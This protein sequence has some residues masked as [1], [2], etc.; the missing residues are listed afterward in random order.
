MADEGKRI[1]TRTDVGPVDINQPFFNLEQAWVIKG[2]VCAWNTFR[3]VRFIQPRG[4][5]FD[6]F[7][8]GIGVFTNETIREWLN[9]TD[10]DMEAYNEK[11]KTGAKPVSRIKKGK[12]INT[13]A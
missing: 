6:G 13:A 3:Q 10:E 7:I 12:R 2:A 11:Y 9:L 4:G 8:G 1:K 5:F